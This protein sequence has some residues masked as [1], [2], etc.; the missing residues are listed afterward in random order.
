MSEPN[1]KTT[2]KDAKLEN[3]I[4]R[5]NAIQLSMRRSPGTDVD[6]Y[7]L[8]LPQGR[9]VEPED[10]HQALQ[11]GRSFGRF[12]SSLVYLTAF[13]WSPACQRR[14]KSKGEYREL[15][16]AFGGWFWENAVVRNVC[17]QPKLISQFR[18]L[19]LCLRKY[20]VLVNL[21][22]GTFK[23]QDEQVSRS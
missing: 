2:T 18:I 21:K 1:K 22:V 3:E 16:L 6:A 11:L 4:W 5:D 13:E 8:D 17:D 20:D 10:A 19:T 9:T 12:L 15:W 23:K 14:H 7:A